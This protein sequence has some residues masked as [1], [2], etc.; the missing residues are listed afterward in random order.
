MTNSMNIKIE[1]WIVGSDPECFLRNRESKEIVSA[2]PYIPGSKYEPYQIPE[3][4]KGHMIQTDNIM[5]E[6]CLPA[7]SN[8]KELKKSF[9]DCVAYT[10]KIIPSELE[11]AVLASA[12][13]AEQYLNHEQ[14]K[15]F[16]CDPDYN[17][18]SDD[19]NIPP[20]SDT[21]LR[22]CG[23]HIHIGY[24]NPDMDV[25][26][27]LIKALDIY[28][29]IPSILLDTDK[30]RKKMYGKAGAYRLKPYGVEYRGLSN[31]WLADNEM[32]NLIF[33]GIRMAVNMINSTEGYL[34]RMADNLQMKVQTCINTGDEVLAFELVNQLG[35]GTLLAKSTV[36][37]D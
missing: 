27:K 10:N 17:A 7:T 22:T 31:F 4:S 33:N 16:G 25:S 29:G 30:D 18:W 8:W 13:V 24:D 28:L 23:G 5:T 6:Y 26:I 2:I 34:D 35:L 11:V 19:M 37:I 20:E 3:L 15:K 32:M 14:A 21:N 1:N 9:D 36:Y 12:K